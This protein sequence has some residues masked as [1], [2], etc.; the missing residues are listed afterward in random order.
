MSKPSSSSPSAPLDVHSFLALTSSLVALERSAEISEEA[1]WK[2][3]KNTRALEQA[4]VLLTRMVVSDVATGLYGRCLLTLEPARGGPLKQSELSVRDIVE[5]STQSPSGNSAASGSSGKLA[6]GI[7]YRMKETSITI[8][9]DDFLDVSDRVGQ[10]SILKLANQ[11]TYDRYKYALDFVQKEFSGG[12]TA[13]GTGV[14]SRLLR[15]L[16]SGVEPV[17]TTQSLPWQPFSTT[18][19]EQQKLA[20]QGALDAN[21]VYMI[22]GVSS[23]EDSRMCRVASLLR[24]L[25]HFSSVLFFISS[26]SRYRQDH[27]RGGAHP[28]IRLSRA[29]RARVR[30]EQS[31]GG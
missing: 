13:A 21:D 9:L 19:N 23:E 3:T 30:T 14:S 26:A 2:A 12:G 8:V 5:I 28:S 25:I 22:H 29:A 20:V 24:L 27:H 11:V 17:A 1:A 15:V 31:G 4:G 7:V 6:S 16:Y 18:L 10:M